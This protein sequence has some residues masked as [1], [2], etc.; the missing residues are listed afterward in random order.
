MSGLCGIVNYDGAPVDLHI[1]NQMAAAAG[2]RGPDGVGIWIDGAVGFAHLALHITPESLHEYQPLVSPQGD[3]VLSA[4]ARIDNREE[5]IPFLSTKG[6]L[7]D[8]APTDADVI[9]AAYRYWGTDCPVH[10]IG[11]F[12]FAIWD[13]ARRR[14]FAARDAMAMRAFYYRVEPH[15]VLFGTE[16][17][18]IMVVPG[19]PRRVFEPSVGAHLA[20]LFGPLSRTFFE[21]ITQLEPAHALLVDSAGHRTWRYWD[22]DPEERIEYT[23]EHDYAEHFL[24]LFKEAVRCRLRSVKPVGIFLSGGMDSG[25]I[26]STAGWL[27][28][29]Q[30]QSINCDIHAY[31]FA[32][33]ELPQCDERHISNEIIRHYGFPATNVLADAAWPLKNYPEYG[34]DQDEPFI[35]VYQAL[36]ERTLA[37]ARTEGMGLVLSGDRGD[38]MVG[39][40]ILDYLTLLRT[41][42]WD[43]LWQELRQGRRISGEPLSR[44]VS[45][46]LLQPL[47]ELLRRKGISDWVYWPARRLRAQHHG[48]GSPYPDWLP[49]AFAAQVGLDEL[50]QQSEPQPNGTGFSYR[51]RY[52]LIFAFMH[53]RGVVWSERTQ[54][55]F[56]L[57][58]ADPWSDRRLATFVLAIPQQVLDRPGE[59][60]KRLPRQAM[61]GIMP[62]SVR[63]NAR[64]IVPS[65]LYKRALREQA[66]G[67]ILDLITD[68]KAGGCGYIDE[69]A[70][71]A[72]YE[73]I[74]RGEP[75]HAH[76]WWAL[77]LEMWLRQ[78]WS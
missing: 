57:G 6:H 10:L 18:Q 17:K 54:A 74:C 73:A 24:E 36:I 7:R 11:D 71:R 44:L 34:P 47:L 61:R 38:L 50:L 1:L 76:F 42:R 49:L 22:I 58:F 25:C 77:T 14:F 64:K 56:G 69:P 23:N 59:L 3:L 16:I 55:R 60:N 68:S 28:Q 8:G 32:F 40:W 13:R 5:L 37:A 63:Q 45:T 2:H 31:C 9:L 43:A 72:H 62:E 20:G 15:R 33:E 26:A 75:D 12:A 30:D 27:H 46:H 70:L 35:G 48:V 21:G 66:R 19:V 67:T 78:H 41:R 51:Q 29:Q 65:P 4:D 53:M 39:G 52:G